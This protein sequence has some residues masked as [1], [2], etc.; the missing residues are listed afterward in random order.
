MKKLAKAQMGK[1]IKT[2][3]KTIGNY[4]PKATE[5]ITK[6]VKSAV[7]ASKKLPIKEGVGITSG[8]V[9]LGGGAALLGYT[10]GRSDA[11]KKI[12]KPNTTPKKKMGGSKKSC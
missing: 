8:V 9:G 4:G 2:A 10:K 12:K 5:V 11:E 7:N 6:S 1:I 3:A